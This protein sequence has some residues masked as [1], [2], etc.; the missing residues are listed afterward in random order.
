MLLKYGRRIERF[1]IENQIG[2]GILVFFPQRELIRRA[3]EAWQRSN[4]VK[5]SGETLSFGDRELFVEGTM[6]TE[7]R[8]IVELY[9]EKARESTAI[10]IGVFRGRNAEG[11]NFPD[12][13]ART[14]FLVGIPFADYADPVIKAQIDYFNRKSDGLGER[15]YVSDAFRSVNQAAGRGIRHREDWCRFVFMDGRYE[16]REKL[17]SPW[18]S[19]KG[20]RDLPEN[21]NSQVH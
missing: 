1:L 10:L 8:G 7:N 2:N 16:G 19:A 17:I 9:K 14:I 11:S 13:E 12:E 15:W 5:R 4:L 6:A 21:E 20:L 18:I 3:L